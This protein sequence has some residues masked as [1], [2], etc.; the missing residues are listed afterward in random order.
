MR[1]SIQKKKYKNNISQNP[2]KIKNNNNN[3]K[4]KDIIKRF[5]QKQIKKINKLIK[6]KQNSNNNNS[7]KI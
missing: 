3:L 6:I 2:L 1:D 7:N 5:D 4:K